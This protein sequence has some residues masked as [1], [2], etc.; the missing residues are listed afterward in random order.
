MVLSLHMVIEL[1]RLG[2]IILQL[3]T[4][5]LLCLKGLPEDLDSS[6]AECIHTSLKRKNTNSIRTQV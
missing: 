6:L 5:C 3:G 4:M 1:N 2:Y